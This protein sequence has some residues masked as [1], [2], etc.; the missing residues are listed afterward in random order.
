[1]PAPFAVDLCGYRAGTGKPNTSDAS[2][3]FSVELGRALFEAMGVSPAAQAQHATGTALSRAVADDL[4]RRL[5][6]AGSDLNV[7]PEQALSA[8]EQ[9][10]H[11]ALLA[12]VSAGPSRDEQ[13]A[14]DALLR[15]VRS[16]ITHPRR[17]L[18]RLEALINEYQAAR[19]TATDRRRQ[20]VEDVGEE[21]L[22]KLDVTGS[23]QL[24]DRPTP[25][26]ELGLSLKWSLRTDRA[27]DCRS[28]GAKMAALRRGRMPHFA[29]ITMEP[30]PYM[31]NILG[32]GSGE[33]DCVYHL[34]LPSLS[35]AI[36]ATCAN[37]G[38]RR[39]AMDT[40]RRLVEQQ[41]LR[42]YDE[43]VTY[44]QVL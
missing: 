5:S 18:D 33:V 9:F 37:H 17:S 25:N 21:N 3:A 39:R 1:M 15:F 26:L 2:D 34:D 20:L 16:R 23:R 8:F 42:D 13:K 35:T 22:L 27:Q 7:L 28:Q 38:S 30:R 4:A 31:L 41:R 10:R 32:G 19:R 44:A 14:W 36:E 6:E 29:A 12:S 43:L 11:V 24:P 40:F